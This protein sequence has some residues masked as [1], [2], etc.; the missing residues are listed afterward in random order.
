MSETTKNKVDT[1]GFAFP[2]A[3]TEG[4]YTADGMTLLD[5]FA[6][7]AMQG[8]LISD[9]ACQ[10]SYAKTAYWAYEQARAM[11]AEKRRTET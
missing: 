7:K 2:V 4:D 3:A 1:G 11:L 6:A 10:Q 8:F 9:P 5:Y